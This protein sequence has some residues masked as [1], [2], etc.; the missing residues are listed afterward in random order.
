M[1]RV[2]RSVTLAVAVATLS[3]VAASANAASSSGLSIRAVTAAPGGHG[4]LDS[5]TLNT[6]VVHPNLSFRVDVANGSTRRTATV[7]LT[8]SRGAPP[9]RAPVVAQKVVQIGADATA[10][11]TFKVR[12]PV[13]FAQRQLLKVRVADVQR[14]KAWSRAFPI[15]FALG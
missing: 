8:L 10:S 5:R 13:A 15:I 11:V 3:V 7:T 14:H 9:G 2:R 4:P 12:E 1:A 6:V